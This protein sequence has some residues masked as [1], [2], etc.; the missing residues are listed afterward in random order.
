MIICYSQYN[1]HSDASDLLS[2][3]DFPAISKSQDL[4]KFKDT[5][6]TFCECEVSK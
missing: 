1:G 5:Q 6:H 4:A 2:E 3:S